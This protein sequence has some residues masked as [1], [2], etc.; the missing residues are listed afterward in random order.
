MHSAIVINN[1]EHYTFERWRN[2]K[3]HEILNIYT[4][5]QPQPSPPSLEHISLLVS[6]DSMPQINLVF[7]KNILAYQ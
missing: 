4:P 6:V 1:K 5:P 2:R 3:Y 7:C